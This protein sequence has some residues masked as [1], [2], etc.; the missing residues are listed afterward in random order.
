M[1]ALKKLRLHVTFGALA[2]ILMG[3]L[4]LVWADS[5]VKAFAWVIGVILVVIGVTQFLGKLFG[6]TG[7]SSGMLIG[8]LIA[9]IGVWVILHQETA[10]GIVPMLIGVV[11]VVHGLQGISLAF[12]GRTVKMPH[13][14]VGLI[15]GI[16]DIVLGCVC[17]V[18]AFRLVTLALQVMGVMMIY[19]GIASC[20]LVHRVNRAEKDI[21]DS[22]I[23]SETTDDI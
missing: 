7:R 2:T 9:V 8:G 23:I 19:D 12:S 11:L 20:L 10:A 4:F 5:I 16:L 3:V 1:E 15:I 18:C 21:I 6:D 14:W 13:W 22:R 17:I